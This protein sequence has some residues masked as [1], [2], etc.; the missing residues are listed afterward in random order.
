M[1]DKPV[2]EML[3]KGEKTRDENF[4]KRGKAINEMVR[5]YASVGMRSWRSA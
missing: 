5:L 1:H 4:R 3:S 2:G